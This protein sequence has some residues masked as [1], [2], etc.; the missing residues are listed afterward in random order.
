M[1]LE[2]VWLNLQ[3][4]LYSF[5]SK[6]FSQEQFNLRTIDAITIGGSCLVRR[7]YTLKKNIP[8]SF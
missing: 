4:D 3:I 2:N 6:C 5:I 8:D 7:V 1:I